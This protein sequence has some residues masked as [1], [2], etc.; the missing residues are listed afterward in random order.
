MPSTPDS[1]VAA[2][3]DR[4]N[5]ETPYHGLGYYKANFTDVLDS[6]IHPAAFGTIPMYS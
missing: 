6:I 2:D 1:I 3:G 4:F 5:G